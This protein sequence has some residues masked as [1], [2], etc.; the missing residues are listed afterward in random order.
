MD[1]PDALLD[2]AT[3]SLVLFYILVEESFHLQATH[4]I[5][6]Y[7]P[8]NMT[9]YDH[10]TFPG[11]VPKSFMPSLLL[12]FLASPSL[13]AY[14]QSWISKFDIQIVVRVVL[15]GLTVLSLASIRDAVKARFGKDVAAWYSIIGMTEFHLLY[16]GSR[17]LPNTF[18]FVATNYALACW[19]LGDVDEDGQSSSGIKDA[20]GSSSAATGSKDGS[21]SSNSSSEKKQPKQETPKS[22][23]KPKQLTEGLTQMIQIFCFTAAVLRAEISVFAASIILVEWILHPS[24]ISQSIIVGYQAAAMSVA[25]TVSVDMYFWNELWMWPEAKSFIYNVV[26]GK[27]S[28]WGVEPWH[29]YF[30]MHLPK[31]MPLALPI[32]IYGVVISFSGSS[33]AKIRKY[34]IP[35][36]MYVSMYSILPHKEWR[37]VIYVIPL[38]N[39]AASVSLVSILKSTNNHSSKMLLTG[40]ILAALLSTFTYSLLQ[41]YVSSMNYPGGIALARL[42]TLYPP[43]TQLYIHLDTY[44]CTTGASLFGQLNNEW[45]YSKYENHTSLSEYVDFGY[46][47]LITE[48]ASNHTTGGEWKVVSQINGYSGL[49]IGSVRQWVS[50]QV[51]RWRTREL[52]WRPSVFK[53]YVLELP[54]KV[55]VRPLLYILERT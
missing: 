22:N 50:E 5:M 6:L 26:Y 44:T 19:I 9:L 48:H 45:K 52:V 54:V 51:Q 7:G 18:A 17:T 29:A 4:D 41:L 34:L 40:S 39:M 3:F 30:S 55:V 53:F 32:S 10:F 31:L 28:N 23:S 42:H 25:M 1:I 21:K 13:L 43:S 46:T 12:S 11:A 49:R 16:Y 38:F 35:A 36:L 47:H 20:P 8:I 14:K 2:I 33:N 24:I 27:S 15:G 37:F